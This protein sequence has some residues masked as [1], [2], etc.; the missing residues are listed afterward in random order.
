DLVELVETKNFRGLVN[1]LSKM[2]SHK[3]LPLEKFLRGVP[4]T[5]EQFVLR[6]RN[7][8]QLGS[9]VVVKAKPKF[10]YIKTPLMVN[11]YW[12]QGPVQDG[13]ISDTIEQLRR[14]DFTAAQATTV[15]FFKT[16]WD[17]TH[18]PMDSPKV[19]YCRNQ[20]RRNQNGV[21]FSLFTTDF[22]PIG[23]YL[24]SIAE[25]LVWTCL[26]HQKQGAKFV[27]SDWEIHLHQQEVESR[28]KQLKDLTQFGH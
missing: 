13:E 20:I 27:L 5:E 11:H 16:D 10:K 21:M 7:Y 8:T 18:L 12:V 6:K 17:I 2:L 28:K 9:D 4:S 24:S 22:D 23:A 19:F 25:T 26:P 1:T 15:V 14:R 3:P